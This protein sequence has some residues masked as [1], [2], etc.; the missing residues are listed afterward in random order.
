MKP[1][2]R[3]LQMMKI[4]NMQLTNILGEL[5]QLR[6]VAQTP[7]PIPLLSKS[8]NHRFCDLCKGYHRIS[9]WDLERA[10]CEKKIKGVWPCRWCSYTS[11]KEQT[12]KSHERRSHQ[13]EKLALAK[14]IK[15]QRYNL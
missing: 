13:A 11:Q 2:I 5:F 4:A 8:P 15:A 12:T 14:Q 3:R 9:H 7:A 10:H 1:T 6:E